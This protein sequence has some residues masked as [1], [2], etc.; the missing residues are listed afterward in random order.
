MEKLGVSIMEKEKGQPWPDADPARART[1]LGAQ[2][3]LSYDHPSPDVA[4]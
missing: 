2:R 3:P 1:T 4:A